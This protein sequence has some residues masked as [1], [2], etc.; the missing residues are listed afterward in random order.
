[1]HNGQALDGVWHVKD[2]GSLCV[3]YAGNAEHCGTVKK[4]AG[5]TF[6]RIDDSDVTTHWTKISDGKAL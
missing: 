3:H 1:M 4:N 2:N 6:T 5:G